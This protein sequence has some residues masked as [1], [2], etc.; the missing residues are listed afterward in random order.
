VRALLRDSAIPLERARAAVES[1]LAADLGLG[2]RLVPRRR[3]T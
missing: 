3:A 1:G 2:E